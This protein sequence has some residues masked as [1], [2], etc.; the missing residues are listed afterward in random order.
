V[1]RRGFFNET[2]LYKENASRGISAFILRG[3]YAKMNIEYKDKAFA[4]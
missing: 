3:K 4:Y 2:D 1:L